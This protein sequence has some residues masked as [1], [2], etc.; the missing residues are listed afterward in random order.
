MS[1]IC[2]Y[3]LLIQGQYL[4]FLHNQFSV[5]NG[6]TDITSISSFRHGVGQ[7][8]GRLQMGGM[9]ADEY[10]VRLRPWLHGPLYPLHLHGGSAS[11][12]CHPQDILVGQRRGVKDRKSPCSRQPGPDC[13]HFLKYAD[14]IP[15]SPITSQPHGYPPV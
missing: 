8:A 7:V 9:G 10:K 12:G 1:C 13:F 15:G 11:H 6:I 4:P 14:I 3:G 2:Q 5:D